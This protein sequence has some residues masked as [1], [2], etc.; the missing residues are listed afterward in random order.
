MGYRGG[1]DLYSYAGNS[2]INWV[3]SDGTDVDSIYK[4]G[5][6]IAVLPGLLN[7]FGGIAKNIRATEPTTQ[8]GVQRF[9]EPEA[10]DNPVAE[11]AAEDDPGEGNI[12]SLNEAAGAEGAGAGGAEGAGA[13]G[14]GAAGATMALP[15]AV[16]AAGVVAV[17]D[18]IHY[19]V[20]GQA[21]GPFTSIGQ[22]IGD[23]F[24]P[25]SDGL[26]ALPRRRPRCDGR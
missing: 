19:G 15:I 5:K 20:T 1:V 26:P 9:V 12:K 14:A 2:P 16:I 4:W 18:L 22:W 24:F 11:N 23:T 17:G 7:H 13:G 10:P 21:N 25:G 8:P 6:L 3:D